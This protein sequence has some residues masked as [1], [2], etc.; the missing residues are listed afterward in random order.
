[1]IQPEVPGLEVAPFSENSD[2]LAEHGAEV[3]MP[4]KMP[5][6]IQAVPLVSIVPV[7]PTLPG[8]SHLLVKEIS[9]Q[10][11]HYFELLNKCL[12]PDA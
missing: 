12:S 4:G 6:K 10:R 11:W 5:C 3:L 9:I 2:A 7:N 8:S 1:M